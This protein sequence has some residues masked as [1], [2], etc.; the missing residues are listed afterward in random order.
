MSGT[1]SALGTMHRLATRFEAAN[2]D[3]HVH[4]L[5]SVGSSGAFRAV[6]EG[7]LDVGI[8]A[9][10]PGPGE[11]ALRLVTVPYARTPFVFAVGPGS[12]VAG[13]TA[14]EAVRIYRGEIQ[15]WPSGERVRVVLRP[16]GD[17]DTLVLRGISSDMAAA[18][19]AADAREGMLVAATNQQCDDILL[20]TPGAIGPSTLT[21][22]VAEATPLRALSW[23]RVAPTVENLAS[24]A[25]PLEKTLLLVVRPSPTPA[26][27]RFLAF[28]ASPEAR[29][30]IEQ[31][32]NLAVP[33]PAVE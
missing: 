12:N 2:P 30:I 9:R 24:G 31:T 7:A 3:L 15:R 6:A 19:D 32:G 16:R 26:V 5:P 17:V 25:Y 18:V 20:T 28:L 33:L 21:Q 29:R 14:D 1:G 11:R 23:N 13:I 22:I 4:L 8:S 10:P 27:R